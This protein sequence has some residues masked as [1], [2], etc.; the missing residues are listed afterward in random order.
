MTPTTAVQIEMDGH[1]VSI[2]IEQEREQGE[3]GPTNAAAC[4]DND[5]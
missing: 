5:R 3:S 4:T 2:T 1:T